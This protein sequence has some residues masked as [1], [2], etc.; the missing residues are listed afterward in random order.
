MK[1]VDCSKAG[2]TSII[3]SQISNIPY[4]LIFA[5]KFNDSS[6]FIMNISCD[7]LNLSQANEYVGD[8][9]ILTLVIKY[10]QNLHQADQPIRM[11]YSNQIKLLNIDIKQSDPVYIPVRSEDKSGTESDDSSCECRYML[12]FTISIWSTMFI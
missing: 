6:I 2:Y 10:N 11:Q 8:V 7:Y 3:C 4:N 5:T 9:T 1:S 12:S